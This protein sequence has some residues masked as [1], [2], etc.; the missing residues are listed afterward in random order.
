MADRRSAEYPHK[1][2]REAAELFLQFDKGIR[3]FSGIEPSSDANEYLAYNISQ[4]PNPIV[5][6]DRRNSGLVV[7]LR[8]RFAKITNTVDPKGLCEK[9][10]AFPAFY[11][12][13][14]RIPHVMIRCNST[15]RIEYV[16]DTIRQVFSLKSKPSR[17]VEL[18][19]RDPRSNRHTEIV[20]KLDN[21]H[22]VVEGIANQIR[23][24]FPPRRDKNTGELVKTDADRYAAEL[25]DAVRKLQVVLGEDL[26]D[27]DGKNDVT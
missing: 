5:Y 13:P 16:I 23:R 19:K 2:S 18:I 11:K 12:G 22:D 6:C 24:A 26:H 3:E 17:P 15:N 14:I 7:R 20:K 1:L 4:K 9:G 8:I 27:D 10:N 25:L 21:V